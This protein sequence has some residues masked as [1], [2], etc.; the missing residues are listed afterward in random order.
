M[1]WRP[2]MLFMTLSSDMIKGLHEIIP[3]KIK[4]VHVDYGSYEEEEH[5]QAESSSACTRSNF[6]PCHPSHS[7]PMKKQ[8]KIST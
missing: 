7:S 4:L 8:M 5:F 2:Y 3:P 1:K 6:F